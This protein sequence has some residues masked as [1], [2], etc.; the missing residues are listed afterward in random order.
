MWS[1]IYAWPWQ[2][3]WAAVSAVFSVIAAAIAVWALFRWKKQDELKAKLTFKLA[4]ADYAYCLMELP[5]MLSIE[6]VRVR[7]QVKAQRL[8]DLL[9]AC[10][11][12]WIA[13]EG[14]LER[15]T[16][17]VRSWNFI[18]DNHKHYLSGQ[19]DRDTLGVYC[20]GII[21]EKFIFK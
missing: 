10:N 8:V 21:E 1:V 5:E 19:I 13:M 9:S 17:V 11:H 16:E 15:E 2:T 4:I 12:A 3:I 6:E 18:F 20:M 7:H 14:L